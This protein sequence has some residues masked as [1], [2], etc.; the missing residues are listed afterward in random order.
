MK[1]ILC[2][3]LNPIDGNGRVSTPTSRAIISDV[4]SLRCKHRLTPVALERAHSFMDRA[5]RRTVNQAT[6]KKQERMIREIRNIAMK[7][8]PSTTWAGDR[9]EMAGGRGI[10]SSSVKALANRSSDL[11]VPGPRVGSFGSPGHLAGMTWCAGGTGACLRF[12]MSVRV[13]IREENCEAQ[14]DIGG[15]QGAR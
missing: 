4:H 7:T 1:W 9:V 14:I 3:Y 12:P 15:W 11:G 13:E 8:L 5:S 2:V 6:A 10:T